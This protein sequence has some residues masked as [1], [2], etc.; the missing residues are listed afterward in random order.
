MVFTSVSIDLTSSHFQYVHK[1]YSFLQHSL[2]TQA[3]AFHIQCLELLLFM[4]SHYPLY[5]EVTFSLRYR[6]INGNKG[7]AEMTGKQTGTLAFV[8]FWEMTPWQPTLIFMKEFFW[9]NEQPLC[10]LSEVFLIIWTLFSLHATL[11]QKFIKTFFLCSPFTC[12]VLAHWYSPLHVCIYLCRLP[13][14]SSELCRNS[15][16][17]LE[18][19]EEER[20]T[21]NVR[22]DFI[23]GTDSPDIHVRLQQG[24]DA[25]DDPAEEA[26]VQGLGHGVADISGF[27]HGVGADDGLAPG[28]HTLGS[29]RF[30]EFLR[31]DAEERRSWEKRRES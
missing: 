29:Q 16:W 6:V 27:V 19:I 12:L 17:S 25:V 10:S 30:L 13:Q 24:V 28:D 4:I 11:Y 1:Q 9:I 7:T 15:A 14:R 21:A 26:P 20:A 23:T 18:I 31:A 2:K 8:H 3:S 22:S 5:V